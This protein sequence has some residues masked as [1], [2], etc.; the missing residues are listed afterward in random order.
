MNW[1]AALGTVLA[2]EEVINGLSERGSHPVTRRPLRQWM[3]RITAYAN[4]LEKDL[5]GLAWPEGTMQ[6]QRQWIGRSQ[7]AIVRFR[8]TGVGPDTYIEAYTTRPDT[9]LGVTYLVVA[10]EHELVSQIISAKG[11]S[12]V[13]SYVADS[14][15]KSDISRTASKKKTG[16]ALGYEAVHPLTGQL[17]PVW[18]ADYVLAGYGTG[19]VMAVP[20]HDARDYEF[21]CQFGLPVKRVVLPGPNAETSAAN[22]D[23]L[24]LPFTH[25]GIVC[26][27]G[28]FDGMNSD[29]CAVRVLDR[30]VELK[31]GEKKEMYK[32][33][34]W[35]FSRQRY[36]GEPIPIYFPVEFIDASG[37]IIDGEHLDPRL[38]SCE[39]RVCYE[40][41]LPVPD[42]ELPLLLPPMADFSP[43]NDPEGCLSRALDWKYFKIGGNWFARE[44]NTMPQVGTHAKYKF[45]CII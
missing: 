2:N 27:S 41:P 3:L 40:N 12:V 28:E 9:L 36:W 38:A 7:G 11:S 43:Q 5:D 8:L 42:S 35:V 1:C 15:A 26:N 16:I 29:D 13:A 37:R 19:A 30:L 20:A 32:L 31:A 17:L 33:H 14:S 34:D 21:A 45:P 4:A 23:Q 24:D 6:A 25:R 10:P 44:T 18:C 39:H 22:G